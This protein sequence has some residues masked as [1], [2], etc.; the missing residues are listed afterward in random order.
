[1]SRK[2]SDS[3]IH[4]FFDQLWYG[5]LSNHEII[6]WIEL[7]PDLLY[8]ETLNG[9]NLLD[10]AA[11]KGN[12]E[13][14]SYLL[15]RGLDLNTRKNIQ[16]LYKSANVEIAQLLLEAGASLEHGYPDSILFWSGRM[17]RP[18][19]FR[20][21]IE[22][23]QKI[24]RDLV[25]GNQD[26]LFLVAQYPNDDEKDDIG[27]LQILIEYGANLNAIQEG[28][29]FTVVE[30]AAMGNSVTRFELLMSLGAR[31][32]RSKVYR[33]AKKDV[34]AY[35]EEKYPELILSE[36]KLTTEKLAKI[37]PERYLPGYFIQ[38]DAF[39][40]LESELQIVLWRKQKD[41][42]FKP[43]RGIQLADRAFRGIALSPDKKLCTI[44]D[45][46]GL[47]LKDTSTLESVAS[48]QFSPG[49]FIEYAAFSLCG[50][51]IVALPS[52]D[53]KLYVL[54]LKTG[55]ITSSVI[56]FT[57]QPVSL[58]FSGDAPLFSY[59]S[60]EEGG[61]ESGIFRIEPD[62]TV[63]LI[64]V[65]IE[66]GNYTCKFHMHPSL[67]L[68]RLDN[69][70][71]S[72]DVKTYLEKPALNYQWNNH[73]PLSATLKWEITTVSDELKTIYYFVEQYLL[74]LA[75]HKATYLLLENGKQIAEHEFHLG[76]GES[77]LD[78]IFETNQFLVGTLQHMKV[79]DNPI[80]LNLH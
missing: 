44:P 34:K 15:K 16:S 27:C 18:E 65:Y 19:V 74:V 20:F 79:I 37:E 2:N 53:T 49:K 73:Y 13:L 26:T 4:P 8:A 69:R 42:S 77:I 58:S 10:Y 56:P 45:W 54:N 1:M 25:I 71:Y 22:Q 70:I 67:P 46:E 38:E 36:W 60:I 40:S 6:K 33:Y 5:G 68:F 75:G 57:S 76:E 62:E 59:I 31:F 55:K 32:N 14:L 3:K 72:Y 64:E 52:Q 12:A 23:A 24:G 63:R 51:Y 48:Y 78:Y 61:A 30:E 41:S 35:I 7:E 47:H 9:D 50:K 80:L 29:E 11:D 21:L 66:L 39:L 28:N 17:N 43:Y